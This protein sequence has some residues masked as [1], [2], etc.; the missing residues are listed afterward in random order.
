MSNAVNEIDL[1]VIRTNRLNQLRNSRP[2]CRCIDF[3]KDFV[4]KYNIKINK[5]CYS[6]VDNYVVETF[7]D[8]IN[9]SY[10]HTPKSMRGL[11]HYV[12]NQNTET[13]Q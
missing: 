9:S 4:D 13:V 3:M 7:D 2:C 12:K 8:I 10:K 6:V 1:I 11:A 5:I